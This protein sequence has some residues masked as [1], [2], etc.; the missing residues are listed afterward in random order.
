MKRFENLQ[1]VSDFTG[2][3]M[4][5]LNEIETDHLSCNGSDIVKNK[6]EEPTCMVEIPDN[7]T[8]G[9]TALEVSEEEYKYY[10]WID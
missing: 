5:H 7:L 6:S 1:E 9:I 3:P 8:M 10:Y 4:A 2:I